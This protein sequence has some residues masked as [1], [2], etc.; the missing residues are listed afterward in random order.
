MSLDSQS[1]LP[2]EKCPAAGGLAKALQD[3]LPGVRPGSSLNR[4]YRTMKPE[5][6]EQQITN[7]FRGCVPGDTVKEI[8][9]FRWKRIFTLNVDDA[10]ERA[11]ET[12]ELSVQSVRPFNY[13]DPYESIRDLRVLPIVHL[14][15]WARR[16]E[17]EYIFD[18]KEYMGAIS[19]NNIWAH[20]LGTLI[21]TE[22]F[23]VLG[24]SL[25]EPDITYFLSD[26]ANVIERRDRPPSIIVEPFPDAGTEIDCEEYKMGLFTGSALEFLNEVNRRFPVRPTVDEAIA[27]NLGDIASA[28]IDASALTEF[29]SDFERVPDD[30]REGAD[31][32][33]NFAYGHQ[34]TW[35][36][37]Q[38]GRDV[39]RE[40]TGSLE[41]EIIKNGDKTLYVVAG[42]PGAGKTTQL[43]RL[44]WNIAQSGA[45]CFWLRSVG[46]IRTSSAA[47]VLGSL[48]RRCYVF[49]DNLADNVSEILA[50]Q[51]RLPRDNVVF[52]GAERAYRIGHV[53]R[54]LGG[55]VLTPEILGPVGES[56]AGE[57]LT[58][59]KN[60]GLA[61]P[62][63]QD[64]NL[65]PVAD[66]VVAVACC[67]ILNNFE[68]LANIID[69]SLADAP[70]DVDCYVFAALAAHCFRQGV[71]YDII[72]AKFPGYQVETQIDD[73]A[74][75]PLKL[76]DV[77]GLELVTPLNEAVSD[78]VLG[79]F[80][81]RFPDRSL[82]L[83]GDL[84][85]AIRP[86]VSIK[87]MM[88]GDPAA[89]IASRLFDFDEV[90]KPLL[91]IQGAGL[92]YEA[93]KKEWKWNSRYW[94]QIA[95]YRLDLAAY[96]D[97]PAVRKQEAELAV[98]HARFAKTIERSH[99]FTMTTIGRVIFGKMRLLGR[100]IPSELE[101][102]LDA[103][104]SAIRIEAYKGRVTVH[105]F[106][107]LFKG[108]AES[109]EAGAVLSSEQKSIV[110]SQ[111]ERAMD[112]FRRDQD[113]AAEA[114][115]MRKL[116]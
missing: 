77:S 97:D 66:E 27:D 83:F 37:I 19:S 110:R 46:R 22:P 85:H 12:K 70:Q 6:I 42:G 95:Q 94:H 16:P 51:Q 90:V 103:L 88:A 4:L 64:A 15:G 47:A 62:P 105:P 68:P 17:D 75:L 52:V 41:A 21:R 9:K 67:R 14:H 74:A 102:A 8:A 113:L 93:T 84:A 32:G 59:Y 28:K 58:A 71:E 72:S 2:N 79:R 60:Y 92:F 53:R 65:S 10:L 106:M 36:D 114:N 31:G 40:N 107:I 81:N 11:Y 24:S 29:H 5:Q 7:R 1:G 73:E 63:Q 55:G 112:A 49:V 78:S 96:A 99:Q 25:E 54:V 80:T 3:A 13:V 43:K 69:K 115:R 111:I 82:K 98:Q 86:R 116:I 101:E 48:G 57:L 38:N 18:I 87:A 26:R 104:S 91:G 76:E 100:V 20:I 89:R 61:N 56:I 108:L 39:S 30:G 34:P 33:T 23:I 35:L 44:A 50:L 45:P 109:L